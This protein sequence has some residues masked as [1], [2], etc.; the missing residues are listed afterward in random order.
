MNAVSTRVSIYTFCLWFITID[1]F[2]ANKYTTD[3]YLVMKKMT[4]VMKYVYEDDINTIGN[5][6]PKIIR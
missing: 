2:Q 5:A 3:T 6:N 4:A 1:R